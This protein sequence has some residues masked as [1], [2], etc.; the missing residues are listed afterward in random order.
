MRFFAFI[1]TV[2]LFTLSCM[3]CADRDEYVMNAEIKAL[4]TSTANSH[5]HENDHCTPICVCS[6]CSVFIT[7]QQ[8]FSSAKPVFF[9]RKHQICKSTFSFL[10]I[11]NIWQ[12]PKTNT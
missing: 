3:P 9:I 10:F 7:F 4:N 5:E 11:N 1:M 12:P 8:A 2:Y 6:C